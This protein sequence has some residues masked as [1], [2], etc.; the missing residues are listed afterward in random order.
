MHKH[1]WRSSLNL[2]TQAD[3]LSYEATG[4]SMRTDGLMTSHPLYIPGI[5]DLGQ[6]LGYFDS[7]TYKKV[8]LNMLSENLKYLQ[9]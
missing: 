2:I 4:K 8:V 9:I 7:I 6:I 3:Y 5:T 1:L